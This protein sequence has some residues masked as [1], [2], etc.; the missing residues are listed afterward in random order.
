MQQVNL[1][2]CTNSSGSTVV[3]AQS[4]EVSLSWVSPA[5][6]AVFTITQVAE[7][8]EIVFEFRTQAAGEYKWSWSI[9]WVARVSG[10]RERARKTADLQVFE[11]NGSFVSCSNR[12]VA[13]FDEKVL[14]GTLSVQVSCNGKTLSRTVFIK[15]QNPSAQDVANYIDSLE[16]MSGF[17]K[18]LEQETHTKHF[19]ELDGEPIVAF[20]KGY[21]ITQ[22]TCS[23]PSFEQVWSWK[24]NIVA[25]SATYKDKVR[26]ARKYLGQEGRTY[27]NVQLQHEVFSRWNGGSYHEWDSAGSAWVRKNNLLCDSSAGNIGWSLNS[28]NNTDKTEAQLHE[29]DKD[30]Y[31]KGTNGQSDE[32]PWVYSG[33]CYA[34]HVLGQ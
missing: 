2:G 13:N 27:T 24:A 10:L 23:A 20:D 32:H 18:L 30:K 33:V 12:W 21:G 19:I 25:G 3:K 1:A 14:G 22:M 34:D 29:R 28:E 5:E 17:D 26:I 16:G 4:S 6:N 11:E 15:G 8:P 31:S 9:K 7:L